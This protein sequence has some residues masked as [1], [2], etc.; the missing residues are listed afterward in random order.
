MLPPGSRDCGSPGVAN[1]S[2]FPCGGGPL[3]WLE[4]PF[5]QAATARTA[6]NPRH[7]L[8]HVCISSPPDRHTL[9][10]RSNRASG[11]LAWD[12][13]GSKPRVPDGGTGLLA[14]CFHASVPVGKEKM[15]GKPAHLAIS[16]LRVALDRQGAAVPVI[17][18]L[19]LDIQEGEI[20]GVVGE[21]GSG[22][23]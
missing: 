12:Y 14:L 4:L 17:D 13:D 11:T 9:P 19:S 21:S 20:V 6:M 22:K 23:T 16:H 1:T 7:D 15:I 8:R 2:T 10:A 18:D 5:P 3:L